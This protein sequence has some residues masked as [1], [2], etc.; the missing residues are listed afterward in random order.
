VSGDTGP[1]GCESPF[2]DSAGA[3]GLAVNLPASVPEVTGVGGS[4]FV[5]GSGDY[6]SS[7]NAKDGTSARSYIPERG[8]N[9]SA[10]GKFLAASGVGASAVYPR[11]YWQTGP[12][13]PNDN[14]RHV[15]DIA[16]SASLDRDPYLIVMNGEWAT[17]GATSASTPFFAGVLALLNEYV[18][19]NGLQTK[20]S[21]GNINPR[22][23][24]FAQKCS[25]VRHTDSS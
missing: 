7:T 11:P 17:V 3:N 5:E 4:E 18:V 15:P 12:G 14:A 16:F 2:T 21:L 1:A 20:P 22:L 6:W 10:P 19:K 8:W 24:Q 25:R 23:Y 9:A 13:V